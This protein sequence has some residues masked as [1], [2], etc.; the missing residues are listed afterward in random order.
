MLN[1]DGNE[2]AANKRNRSMVR[3]FTKIQD[4]IKNPDRQDF[5]LRE[6]TFYP[7]KYY[8]SFISKE[9]THNID[10]IPAKE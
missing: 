1:G 5:S 4:P 7:K 6:E 10:G 3:F 2:N 9:R 8:Y